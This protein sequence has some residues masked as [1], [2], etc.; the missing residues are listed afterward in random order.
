[1]TQYIGC[2]SSKDAVAKVITLWSNLRKDVTYFGDVDNTKD[3]YTRKTESSG[4][5][6]EV[7]LKVKE[8][9][10]WVL[11]DWDQKSYRKIIL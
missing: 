5:W 1:M 6:T 2:S 8:G 9:N 3:C 7:D 4:T 10:K 11:E